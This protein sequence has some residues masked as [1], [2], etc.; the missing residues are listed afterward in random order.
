MEYTKFTGYIGTYTKGD[1]EGIY[2]FVLDTDIGKISEVQLAGTVDNPTY[3]TVSKDQRY[4]YSVIKE[5]I[6][7]GVAA[8]K[9]DPDSSKLSLINKELLEG[10]PPCHV[11]IDS[12]QRYLFSTNYH[13]GTVESYLINQHTGEVAEPSSV[14]HH[15]G[16]GPDER[17][18]K[19]H[20]HYA[21][22][23]P[24]EKY[25]VVVELGSDK[26]FTYE[27]KKDG[28]LTEVSR[29]DI[30][31]G[32]GP[33]HLAFH[34]INKNIAYIMTEFSS[35]IIVLAYHERM[36][37]SLSSKHTKRYQMILLKITKVVRFT[38]AA[39]ESSYM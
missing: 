20:T 12:Q 30:R 23:T 38:S 5:D 37:V 35:E 24:D 25:L 10:A 16:N 36:E 17:Q 4:L 9:I 34:P 13:K 2:S 29:L 32:S 18:E 1:S 21:G 22:M 11:N 33:R 31:P 27:V 6:K 28:Q 26:L 8:F 39:M 7:G 15:E 19:A 14:V 3:I